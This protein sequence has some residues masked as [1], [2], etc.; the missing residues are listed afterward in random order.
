MHSFQVLFFQ[1]DSASGTSLCIGGAEQCRPRG[2]SAGHDELEK[3]PP[4][5]GM[6][7]MLVSKQPK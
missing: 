6:G 2:G 4:R 7:S 5:R 1:R 3:Q